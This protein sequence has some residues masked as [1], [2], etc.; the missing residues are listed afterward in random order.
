MV[1]DK[2]GTITRGQPAVTDIRQNFPAGE[3]ELLLLNF[4]DPKVDAPEDPA[5]SPHPI[6]SDL[7]V[8]QA[9]QMGIDKEAIVKNLLYGNVKVGTTVLPVTAWSNTQLNV[10]VPDNTPTGAHQLDITA[11]NGQKTING[12]T[13]HVRGPGYTP[14]PPAWR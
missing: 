11:A 4:A 6:L 8:R 5:K 14:D 3:N 13:L 9:L 12:L 10:S 1:L 2:T 7:K